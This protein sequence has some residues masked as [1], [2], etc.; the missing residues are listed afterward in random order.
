MLEIADDQR[1]EGLDD[2]YPSK[3][4]GL[5]RVLGMR[6]PGREKQVIV[7]NVGNAQFERIVSAV[8]FAASLA[9]PRRFAAPVLSSAR[10]DLGQRPQK[11]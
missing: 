2:E 4:P 9:H 6:L 10:A 5:R 8:I 7:D 3:E 1:F 11:G